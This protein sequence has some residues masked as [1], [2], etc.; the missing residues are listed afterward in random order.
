MGSYVHGQHCTGGRLGDG[1][2]DYVG[3]DSSV[4]GEV[5][6]EVKQ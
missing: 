3:G 4:C 1:S 5:E 6:D 2:A